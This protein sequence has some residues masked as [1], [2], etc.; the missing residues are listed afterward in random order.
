MY[1]GWLFNSTFRT[2]NPTTLLYLATNAVW[3]QIATAIGGPVQHIVPNP[4]REFEEARKVADCSLARSLI[5]WE[6]LIS[7]ADGIKELL[8]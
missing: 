7:F 3:N 8:G 6:P 4:R 1:H 2:S 5:G